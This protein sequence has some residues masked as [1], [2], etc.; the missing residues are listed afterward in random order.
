LGQP[1]DREPHPVDG[2]RDEL[3]K[4][5]G[6][7]WRYPRWP[8]QRFSPACGRRMYFRRG[9]TLAAFSTVWGIAPRSR[10]GHDPAVGDRQGTGGVRKH[11]DRPLRAAPAEDAEAEYGYVG[12]VLATIGWYAIPTLLYVTWALL[13]DGSVRPGCVDAPGASC[14]APRAAALRNLIEGLPQLELAILTSVLVA[15]LIRWVT[16]TWRGLTVG[17]A[18]ALVGAGTAVA[19]FSTLT[20][21]S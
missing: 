15:L 20:A 7:M 13:L 2:S 8:A 21:T 4:T 12:A 3:W 11:V 6:T 17:F 5:L 9:A 16:G 19:L 14:L 18:A 10:K 1:V